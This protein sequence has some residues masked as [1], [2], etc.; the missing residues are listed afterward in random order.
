M[1]RSGYEWKMKHVHQ[2]T[3]E[4][5]RTLCRWNAWRFKWQP[6]VSTI[7]HFYSEGL[8][9]NENTRMNDIEWSHWSNLVPQCDC[10]EMHEHVV[11]KFCDAS[12]LRHLKIC[13]CNW[14][15][16]S[17]HVSHTFDFFSWHSFPLFSLTR[18]PSPTIT[19]VGNGSSGEPLIVPTAARSAQVLRWS[20]GWYSEFCHHWSHLTDLFGVTFKFRRPNEY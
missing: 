14:L 19:G 15:I 1:E 6:R 7:C 16:C 3:S 13:K 8:E 5:Q 17:C 2:C 10:G 4:N 9:P 12:S 18:A 11:S 20:E